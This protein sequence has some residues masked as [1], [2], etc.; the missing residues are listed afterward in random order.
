MGTLTILVESVA[1]GNWRFQIVFIFK[2]YIS[3]PAKNSSFT[4]LYYKKIYDIFIQKICWKIEEIR[5]F[6]EVEE[7]TWETV[8]NL[9]LEL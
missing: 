4:C 1:N 3:N 8:G 6:K 7:R 5:D 2:F 9:G